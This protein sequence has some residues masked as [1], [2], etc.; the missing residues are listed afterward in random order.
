MGLIEQAFRR[1]VKTPLKRAAR[2]QAR[3]AS[4][5]CS[6]GKRYTNP[7]AHTCAPKSDFK[8]RKA[9][10]ERQ[11][12]REAARE[13]K[14]AA[15]ERRKAAAAARRSKARPSPARRPPAHDYRLCRDEECAKHACR[16]YKD[17]VADCP[18]EHV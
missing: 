9:A 8:R 12:K 10:E 1:K 6:C 14:R 3:K 18:L 2:Q 7:L 11:R 4:V 16:A 5:K 15:A 13:R 17:G